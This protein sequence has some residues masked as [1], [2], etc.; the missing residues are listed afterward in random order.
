MEQ[1]LI[2]TW[3]GTNWTIV[4]SPNS[5]TGIHVLN[6][7]ACTSSTSCEAVGY[8][9]NGSS[10]AQTLIESWSGSAWTISSGTNQPSS[11]NDLTAVSCTSA[12]SCTAV[13]VSVNG[14]SIAQT[15]IERLSGGSWT[16]SSS[17]N[18]GTINNELNGVTCTSSTSCVAVGDYFNASNVDQTLVESWSGG[19]WSTVASPNQGAGNNSLLGVSC[20]SSTSCM[21]VGDDIN[22]SGVEQTLVEGWNGSTWS[23]IASPNQGST[24][25][26]LSGVGCSSSTSCTSV[27]AYTS[28]GA[29]QTLVETGPASSVSSS[30]SVT[31]PTGG[32]SWARG[33]LPC[34]HVVV[35]RQ[36]R[37]RREDPAAQVRCGGEN[38]H[39]IGA[40]VGRD[41]H[42]EGS[43]HAVPRDELPDQDHLDIQLQGVRHLGQVLDHLTPMGASASMWMG[44]TNLRRS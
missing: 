27:G 11:T 14:A 38:H 22:G 2:E 5:G 33:S 15:L 35:H 18:P 23:T 4:T 42:L 40:D 17:P 12:T 13:G 36:P 34:D 1:T 10:I 29:S 26:G 21:A 25:N 19:T 3:N 44:S 9:Y 8:A 41:L 43:E 7:V 6:G 28:Y 30:I 24:G 20:A 32:A 16:I 37:R 31:S 39:E